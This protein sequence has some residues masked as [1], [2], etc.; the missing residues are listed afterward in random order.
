MQDNS[1]TNIE[2]L[3][4]GYDVVIFMNDVIMGRFS[5]YTG[6]GYSACFVPS[7]PKMTKTA[8]VDQIAMLKSTC[9]NNNILYYE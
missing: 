7:P 6:Q 4:T 8:T 5:P 2:L 3:E 1:I 9:E